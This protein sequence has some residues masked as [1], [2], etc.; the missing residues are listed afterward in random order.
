MRRSPVAVILA[1]SLMV[2]L[3]APSLFSQED[4]IKAQELSP[5]AAI[6]SAKDWDDARIESE[7]AINACQS[8]DDYEKLASEI[9]RADSGKKESKYSDIFHFM[10][11]KTRV[12]ELSYLTKKNDIDSGR[13]YMSV[14]EKYYNDALACLD[15]YLF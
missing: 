10:C 9:K 1:A 14:S 13:V 3:A 15:K 4:N 7:K 5:I 12:K 6:N 8:Y 11:A 2:F